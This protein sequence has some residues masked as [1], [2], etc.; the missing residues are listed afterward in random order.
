MSSTEARAAVLCVLSLAQQ[1]YALQQQ[2]H[3]DQQRQRELQ[4]QQQQQNGNHLSTATGLGWADTV[5]D[6]VIITG[7]GRNSAAGEAV[8]PTVVLKLL[9]EELGINADC[10]GLHSSAGA[11]TRTSNGVSGADGGSGG[12]SS[13][14]GSK[15]SDAGREQD[16]GGTR[17]VAATA[18]TPAAA[19]AAGKANAGR[20]V[21]SKEALLQWLQGRKGRKSTESHSNL[22][23]GKAAELAV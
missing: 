11:S 15:E 17:G 14:N 5:H 6:I 4:E 7:A 10:G 2:Y 13:M 1:Q 16:Q 18:A 3:Q 8:L 19:A 12:S 22:D 20:V 9:R 21:V 23:A